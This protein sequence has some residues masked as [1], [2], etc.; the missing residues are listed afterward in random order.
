MCVLWSDGNDVIEENPGEDLMKLKTRVSLRLCRTR[1]GDLKLV[2]WVEWGACPRKNVG[3]KT[4]D[5]RN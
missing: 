1:K 2:G 4:A 5:R 3:K